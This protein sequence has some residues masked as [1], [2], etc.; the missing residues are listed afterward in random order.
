MIIKLQIYIKHFLLSIYLKSIKLY[1]LL[2][3]KSYF[4]TIKPQYITLGVSNYI[5][6][7]IDAEITQNFSAPVIYKPND[8]VLAIERMEINSNGIPF[9]NP[10]NKDTNA[11]DQY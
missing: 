6:T 7:N 1:I 11:V 8:Y 10:I 2:Y 4:E 5:K 3:M 9:F